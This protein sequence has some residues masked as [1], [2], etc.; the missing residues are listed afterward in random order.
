MEGVILI[1]ALVVI[2][3]LAMVALTWKQQHPK[4]SNRQP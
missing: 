3:G 2:F 1:A 4:Q